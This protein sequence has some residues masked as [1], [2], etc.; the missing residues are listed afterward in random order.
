VQGVQ[1]TNANQGSPFALGSICLFPVR[2]PRP[3]PSSQQASAAGPRAFHRSASQVTRHH[4]VPILTHTNGLSGLSIGR[5]RYT[6]PEILPEKATTPSIASAESFGDIQT[7]YERLWQSP[8]SNAKQDQRNN[9]NGVDDRRFKQ[10][11]FRV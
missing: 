9:Q 6:G 11:L 5:A 2:R 10:L 8:S 7:C 1:P 4:P 3:Q